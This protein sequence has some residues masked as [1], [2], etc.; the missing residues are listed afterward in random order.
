MI[1]QSRSKARSICSCWGFC[2]A[3]TT[4]GIP[5]KLG[6]LIWKFLVGEP[7]PASALPQQFLL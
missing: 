7:S 2:R 1:G 4:W 5:Q 3:L 6:A